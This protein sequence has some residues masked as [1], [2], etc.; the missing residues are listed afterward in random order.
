MLCKYLRRTWKKINSNRPN[1]NI[2]TSRIDDYIPL[3]SV[4]V[5]EWE[6]LILSEFSK[7]QAFG[8]INPICEKR[9][10]CFLKDVFS[11]YKSELPYHNQNHVF[12]VFQFGMCLLQKHRRMIRN[13]KSIDIQTFCFALL[14]H[15]VGHLGYTNKEMEEL[16]FYT[17]TGYISDSSV[18]SYASS[19]NEHRHV[20]IG[21]VLLERHDI[22]YNRQLF[23]SLI[24]N[25]DLLHHESFLLRY[26]PFNKSYLRDD[27]SNLFKFFMKLSD[28]GHAIR[29]WNVHLSNV[30]NL[31]KERANPLSL[32][33]L[34]KDTIFFNNKF[35]M[36]LLQKEKYL[37]MSLFCKMYT[38]YSDNIDR[39]N[40]I[41]QFF[42][43]A[44]EDE[45]LNP[46]AILMSD[47]ILTNSFPKN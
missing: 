35:L 23:N 25:T 40:T 43:T 46:D 16:S 12:E 31:N 3:H 8:I 4:S 5:F 27:Y 32:K 37:N 28:I 47:T 18:S 10:K 44:G 17:D 26:D 24:Y 45:P 21:C 29:P 9:M 15:D 14:L 20:N 36:P 6:T 38:K 42:E 34:A 7:L 33:D 2:I 22:C 13:S 39:W 1:T 30:I 41:A 19:Y 11:N